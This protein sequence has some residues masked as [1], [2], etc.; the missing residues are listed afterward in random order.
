MHY[1]SPL[2]KELRRKNCTV[3]TR[4]Q[5]CGGPMA[6]IINLKSTLEGHGLKVD[7]NK[8]PLIKP[9]MIPA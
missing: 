1:E 5:A 6:R 4:Y 8:M 3:E 7:V 2:C 9:V